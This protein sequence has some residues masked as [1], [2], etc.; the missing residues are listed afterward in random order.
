MHLKVTSEPPWFYPSTRLCERPPKHSCPGVFTCSPSAPLSGSSVVSCQH[1]FLLPLP[2]P[3]FLSLISLVLCIFEQYH[4]EYLHA[5]AKKAAEGWTSKTS[6]TTS[7]KKYR[8]V[9][10]KDVACYDLSTSD[11]CCNYQADFISSSAINIWL[12]LISKLCQFSFNFLSPV[13]G[14]QSTSEN[15]CVWMCVC[16]CGTNTRVC[17]RVNTGTYRWN[18]ITSR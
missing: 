11:L 8:M 13:Q 2:N 1:F 10:K 9:K 15:V 16:D 5:V 12:K 3:L 6:W 14:Q 18:C 4:D 17:A 7:I